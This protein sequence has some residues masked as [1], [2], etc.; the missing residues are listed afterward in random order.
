M[1]SITGP[2]A[3]LTAGLGAG[4]WSAAKAEIA[5]TEAASSEIE[6]AVFTGDTFSLVIMLPIIKHPP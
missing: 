2:G 6:S 1:A 4:G 3:G 5:S